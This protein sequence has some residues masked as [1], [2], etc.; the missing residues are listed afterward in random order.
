MHLLKVAQI[1]RASAVTHWNDFVNFDA[2][3]IEP[4]DRVVYRPVA[5]GTGH[6]LREHPLSGEIAGLAVDAPW[7]PVV[8]TVG[9]VGRPTSEGCRDA[10]IASGI[11]NYA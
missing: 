9:D 3:W 2:H 1:S 6:L 5:D 10:C 11:F 8:P 7:I 4:C